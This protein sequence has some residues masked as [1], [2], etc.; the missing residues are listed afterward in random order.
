MP[1]EFV[2]T[3]SEFRKVDGVLVPMR[4]EN[5]ANGKST[6]VTTLTKV[7]FPAAMPDGMFRP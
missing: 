7:A 6:G 3:Y 1:L 4:E 5:W 2:T